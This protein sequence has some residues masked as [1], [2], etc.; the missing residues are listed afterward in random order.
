MRENIFFIKFS[1]IGDRLDPLFHVG[2]EK[3][4]VNIVNK[5]K[6]ESYN[7][8]Q[9]CTINRGR[10]GHRP[11]NDPRFYGGKYPFIQTGD[12]VNAS[13]NNS[14]IEYKQTLNELG[15]E[16]SKLFEPPKLL[17]TIAANIGDT[18]ILD[19]SSCFPDSIVALIPKDEK[20]K[21][22]YLN[23]YFKIIKPYIVALAPYAA[24]K[25][26]NNQQLSEIPIILP[27]INI[28]NQIILKM[29][30]AYKRKKEKEKEAQNNLENIDAYFLN[31]LRIKSFSDKKETLEDRVFFRKFSEISSNR[32]D[33]FYYKNIFNEAELNLNKTKNNIVL[34]KNILIF[35]ESGSRPAG[36][37]GNIENGILSLGGEHVNNL[38][39]IE[40]KN[41]KYIPLSFHNKI[42]NTQ[43]KLN[44][45]I[46]VKDGATT[47]KIGIIRNIEH[48]NQNI[49]E[50]VFILRF[51][52]EIN[53]IYIL[54]FLN[55]TIGQIQIKRE[56]TGA[57]VT[58][59]T[60]EAVNKIKIFLPSLEIQNKIANHIQNL[61]DEAQALKDEAIQIFEDAKKE[62]E[63]MILGDVK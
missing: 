56:I 45:I 28:Q 6:Y 14:Q 52:D 31:E 5:A 58:G 10:F 60:K 35:L 7:L 11:R 37:V 38:C 59:L 16:T 8:H 36:G 41:P 43:T 21:I 54:Y 33:A 32:L 15:L 27:P 62:V 44:D 29:E 20:L 48:V 57:T 61:R 55:S 22:D 19:Y 50:H 17:F 26:L 47:G 40:I 1:E 51:L 34:L 49:N 12:I 63:N 30:Q 46:L 4:K 9:L 18:A 2:M 25:N 3:M 53:P 42:L 39:E 24:Q 23:I 13:I